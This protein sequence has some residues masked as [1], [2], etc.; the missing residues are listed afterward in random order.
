MTRKEK[1]R[2]FVGVYHSAFLLLSTH[3]R[4]SLHHP[5]TPDEAL[6]KIVLMD[7]GRTRVDLKI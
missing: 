5:K 7:D 6:G 4:L 3:G 1:K 2:I